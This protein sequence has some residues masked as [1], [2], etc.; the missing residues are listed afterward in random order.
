MYITHSYIGIKKGEL[1]YLIF[2]LTEEYIENQERYTKVLHPMLEEL[3]EKLLDKG[4]VVQTFRN[5]IESNNKEVSDTW[6]KTFEEQQRFGRLYDDIERP[7]L[8]VINSEIKDI[9]ESNF[10][11]LS[12]QD[13]ENDGHYDIHKLHELFEMLIEIAHSDI[14]LI[15][16]LKEYINKKNLKNAEKIMKIDPAIFGI[17]I[18]GR[19]AIKAFKSFINRQ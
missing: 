1:D 7:A 9:T 5:K 16:N 14:D 6:A 19:E 17:G 2:Y 11:L 13:F 10:L 18:N 15:T 3:G 12:L 8:L 4:A